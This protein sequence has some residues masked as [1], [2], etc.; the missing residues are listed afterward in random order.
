MKPVWQPLIPMR[1]LKRGEEM[2]LQQAWGKFYFNDDHK[3]EQSNDY[4]WKDVP[5]MMESDDNPN[6]WTIDVEE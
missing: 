3:W 6:F 4:K 5:L 1:Y 2:V